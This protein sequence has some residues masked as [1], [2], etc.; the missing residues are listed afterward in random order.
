M[1][2]SR[3]FPPHGLPDCAE[4]PGLAPPPLLHKSL[5][6]WR[7]LFLSQTHAQAVA[8]SCQARILLQS[9]K[10]NRKNRPKA[11]SCRFHRAPVEANVRQTGIEDSM[12]PP[13]RIGKQATNT[14]HL[15][16]RKK[17]LLLIRGER[18]AQGLL[19]GPMAAATAARAV[20]S[21]VKCNVAQ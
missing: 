6:S 17:Q 5:L 19:R 13:K 1:T 14:A 9:L 12:C 20:E 16:K 18:F 2:A 10:W 3:N 8:S 7:N 4:A 15:F 11:R 21:S